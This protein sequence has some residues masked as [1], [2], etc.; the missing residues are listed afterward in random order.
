MIKKITKHAR[1]GT[2]IS[3][4]T[5]LLIRKTVLQTLKRHSIYNS[6]IYKIKFGLR[7]SIKR[8]ITFS[9]KIYYLRNAYKNVPLATLV[10]DKI[11]VRK[12]VQ[13]KVG[14][15]ILNILLGAYDNPKDIDY[16]KLPNQFVIK[17]NH[18]TGTNIIVKDKNS[19]DIDAT[20]KQLTEWLKTNFAE[21]L[22]E[23]Q[24]YNIKP[25]I[26]IEKYL[27]N[28]SFRGL[29][30]YKF[31]CFNGKVEFLY[32]NQLSTSYYEGFM[33]QSY[34]LNFE[35]TKLFKSSGFPLDEL[36]KPI[37]IDNMICAASKLSTGFP[38]V[39]V[40][41]YEVDG[42]CVFG[43]MTLTPTAGDNYYINSENQ[44][45]LG[46]LIQLNLINDLTSN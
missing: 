11:E 12:Y 13:D 42:R 1:K 5:N 34:D 19:L 39:R 21:I 33:F 28:D 2:L 45:S 16:T 32:V 4:A 37:T 14:E 46:D 44:K 6:L 15:G 43:E 8:P 29:L 10:S 38:F 26:L 35:K 30:D 17:T 31:Y 22:G 41:F 36:K 3:V 23:M 20:N 9:Q 24:Y 7:E 27:K 18:G 40:D 25:R